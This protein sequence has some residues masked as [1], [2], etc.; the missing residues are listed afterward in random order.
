MN[1]KAQSV[2]VIVNFGNA[3]ETVNVKETFKD[4]PD[5]IT[6]EITGGVSASETGAQINISEDFELGAYESIVAFY[7][8]STTMII[9]NVLLFVSIA[10]VYCC[11]M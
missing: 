6:V 1:K 10:V 5:L 9:S 3:T 11:T 8:S 2:L 4:M 7:N